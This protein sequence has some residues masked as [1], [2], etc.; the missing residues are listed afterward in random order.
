MNNPLR[1]A[2]DTLYQ[3]GYDPGPPET[4]ALQVVK[5]V[6]W[7][8]PYVGCMIVAVGMLA[9]FSLTLVRFLRRRDAEEL[10]ADE[11][12][13]LAEAARA[14]AKPRRANAAGHVAPGQSGGWKALALPC[15]AVVAAGRMAGQQSA[16]RPSRKPTSSTITSSASCRWS[17]TAGSNRSTRWPATRCCCCRASRPFGTTHGKRHPAI[18]WLLDSV[19]HTPASVNYRAF[20]DP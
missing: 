9:H 17:T 13:G 3:S 1:F 14:V 5:N 11:H 20:L 15:L 12:L 2:G 8:I 4:T 7:M 19:C 6:G 18:E 16:R 10:A